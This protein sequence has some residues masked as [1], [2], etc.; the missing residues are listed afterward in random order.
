MIEIVERTASPNLTAGSRSF[1][2]ENNPW[3]K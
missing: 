1:G 2:Q 3:K